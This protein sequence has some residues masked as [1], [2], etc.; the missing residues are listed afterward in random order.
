MSQF[1]TEMQFVIYDNENSTSL[2]VGRDPD[3]LGLVR[4]DAKAYGSELMFE[5]KMAYHVADALMKIARD[6]EEREN[7]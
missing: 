2:T 4:I 3:G 6:I 7:A 1:E 5:P